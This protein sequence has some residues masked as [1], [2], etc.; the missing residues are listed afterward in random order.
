[1][2]VQGP[3]RF[4]LHLVMPTPDIQGLVRK[5]APKTWFNG[6]QKARHMAVHYNLQATE[7]AK[8]LF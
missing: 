7:K 2:P 4:S 5:S 3:N 1:M 8:N 6:I